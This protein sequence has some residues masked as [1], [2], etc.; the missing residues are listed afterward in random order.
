VDCAAKSR[1]RVPLDRLPRWSAHALVRSCLVKKCYPS[2]DAAILA[3][4]SQPD[5]GR[6]YECLLCG[7]WH[8]TKRRG[9]G[10]L[11][12][13]KVRIAVERV[14]ALVAPGQPDDEEGG[15]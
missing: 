5:P 13:R 14:R 11:M 12:L 10:K 1:D 7:C 8:L 2:Q 15:R 6:A 4:R 9:P 3:S